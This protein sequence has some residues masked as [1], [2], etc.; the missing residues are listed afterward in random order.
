MLARHG[1]YFLVEFTLHSTM[2]L[3][4]IPVMEGVGTTSRSTPDLLA[5]EAGQAWT[6]V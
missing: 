3:G 5:S 1:C 2:F 6:K 4:M